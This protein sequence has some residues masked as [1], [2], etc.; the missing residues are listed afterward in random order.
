MAQRPSGL[1]R[2]LS[3][4][5]FR[6]AFAALGHW[7]YGIA[8]WVLFYATLSCPDASTLFTK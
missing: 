6:A 5:H 7:T 8:A 3:S 2:P 4:Q 1:I